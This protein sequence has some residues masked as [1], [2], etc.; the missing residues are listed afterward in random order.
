[1]P[2]SKTRALD[3]SRSTDRTFVHLLVN[4][5]LVSVINFTVWFAITFWV[6][7][8]NQVGAGNGRWSRA[9]SWWT[10]ALSGIWFGS[11]VDRPG[12]RPSCRSRR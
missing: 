8:G 4:T 2:T 6:L 7:P 9:S 5:L 12:R 1:M 3:L 11:L 10:T